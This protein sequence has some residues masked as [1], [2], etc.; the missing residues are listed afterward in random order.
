MA[1]FKVGEKVILSKLMYEEC[2][3]SDWFARAKDKVKDDGYLVISQIFEPRAYMVEGLP[4]VLFSDEWLEPYI[5]QTPSP[6]HLGRPGYMP[7][8]KWF[9]CDA[10]AY[11]EEFSVRDRFAMAALMCFRADV[12][13]APEYIAEKA[14][15][16]ADAMMETR[17][18]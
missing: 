3:G 8:E 1:K 6:S 14:Y 17:K 15:K 16:V 2:E 7:R 10:P 9:P 12:F 11:L 18:I 13:I 5:D 4:S